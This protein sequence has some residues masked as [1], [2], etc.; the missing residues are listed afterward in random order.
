MHVDGPAG[1]SKLYLIDM[2]STYLFDMVVQ[3]RQSDSVL[4]AAP[5]GVAAFSIQEQ[6]L[7]QLI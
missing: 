5:T 6:T 3:C 7:H 1:T 2:I 4:Q